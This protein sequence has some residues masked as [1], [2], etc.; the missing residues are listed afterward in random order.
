MDELLTTKPLLTLGQEKLNEAVMVLNKSL[1]VCFL[2]H[3]SRSIAISTADP[4][5]GD[6]RAKHECGAGSADVQELPIE[7]AIPPR[8]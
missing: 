8:G 1:Q 7:R 6:Q 3:I 5:A 2:F 4:T